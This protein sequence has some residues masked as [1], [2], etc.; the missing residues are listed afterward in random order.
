M[1]SS[2]SLRSALPPIY[3]RLL[4]AFFDE[5]APVEEKAT[6]SNC[7]MCAPPGVDASA[8]GYFRPD[9][10]CCTYHPTLPNYLVG[11]LLADPEPGLAEGRRRI[12]EKIARRIGVTP[13]WIAAPR[14]FRI[15]WEASRERAFGRSLTLRCPYYIE[16]GGLCSIWRHREADCSTFFCKYGAGADGQLFWRTL[17]SYVTQVE[18]ALS[19]HAV[20]LVAPELELVEEPPGLSVEELEDRP[21]D[22]EIYAETFGSWAGREEEYYRRCHEVIE[23]LDPAELPALVD[24]DQPVR[25]E[26]LIDAHKKASAPS[27]PERLILAED[28]K[29]RPVEGGSVV[30]GYSRYEPVFVSDALYE[31]LR[32]LR[33]DEP[34]AA[35]QAR[36]RSDGVELPSEL[37]VSLHQLRVLVTP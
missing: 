20:R 5:P 14:K 21:L 27:L 23:A 35:L 13:R 8:G 22:P 29:T 30:L 31:V 19:K 32:T 34:V 12:R 25:L 33:A 3:R 37:L 4:P 2:D 36:L 10:K 17:N 16:D 15:L 9:V 6:C 18:L 28:L 24:A 7:A 11:A 26:R 1:S